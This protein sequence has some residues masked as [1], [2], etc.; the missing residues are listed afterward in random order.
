MARSVVSGAAPVRWL[1][2]I[3][4]R[5]ETRSIYCRFWKFL[6]LVLEKRRIEVKKKMKK[7]M[8]I[9]SFFSSCGWRSR[10]RKGMEESFI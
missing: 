4:V 8:K 9:L 5:R 2:R 3:R 6:D 7:M 1:E 10:K